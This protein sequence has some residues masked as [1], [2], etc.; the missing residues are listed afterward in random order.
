MNKERANFYYFAAIHLVA[1]TLALMG[2]ATQDKSVGLGGVI[3]AGTGAVLGGIAD[4]G[5]KG[6]YRTRNVI[7]GSVTGGMVGLVA[8]SVI[9]SE[10]EKQK[11]EAFLKGRASAPSPQAGAMPTL[12]PARVESR[13]IEAHG[14]G[15]VWVEG[16]F[17]HHIVEP[18]RWEQE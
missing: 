3:G 14:R 17:E 4:P 12:K 2:C 1:L 15:N 7:L 13:W 5:S 6:K 9:H 8:G 18:S 16:H 11:K 10:T